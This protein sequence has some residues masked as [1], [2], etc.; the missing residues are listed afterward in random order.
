MIDGA[1]R[2]PLPMILGREA[3]GVVEEVGS[4]VRDIRAGD[5]VVLSSN[6]HCGHCFHCDRAQPILCETYLAGG[7]E[8]VHFDGSSKAQ[9]ADGAKLAHLM[10]LGAF[11]GICRGCRR[12]RRSSC[13]ADPVRPYLPDRL[14]AS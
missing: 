1:L 8:G 4:A 5:H 12:S 9:L 7:A 11:S 3:A 14:A 6:P 2:Y 10:F 13:S